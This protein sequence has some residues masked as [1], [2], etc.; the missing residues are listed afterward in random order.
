MPHLP[1]EPRHP[2][3]VCTLLLLLCLPTSGP[4]ASE[5]LIQTSFYAFL[6]VLWPDMSPGWEGAKGRGGW[7]L[8][9]C[10]MWQFACAGRNEEP[11]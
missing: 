11:H 2:W 4:K 8:I 3:L 7:R 1:G 6:G 9:V 10:D 5:F